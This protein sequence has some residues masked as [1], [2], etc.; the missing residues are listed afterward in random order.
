MTGEF[1][2]SEKITSIHG[3]LHIRHFATNINM[4]CQ[5]PFVD[6]K[7]STV[8]IELLHK[9]ESLPLVDLSVLE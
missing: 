4:V 9:S 3:C 6:F 1:Q 7:I 2:K 8:V 5:V